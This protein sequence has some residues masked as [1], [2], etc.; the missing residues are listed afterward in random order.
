M[1]RSAYKFAYEY[2]RNEL[3]Y[4]RNTKNGNM[5][6]QKLLYFSQLVHYAEFGKPLFD[7]PIYAYENGCI[8]DNVLN[9]YRRYHY[10][11]IHDAYE[12]TNS[13][14]SEEQFTLDLVKEVYGDK[15]AEE[16]SD[17]NHEHECWK[18]AYSR[19]YVSENYKEKQLSKIEEDEAFEN[20]VKS[21]KK[22]VDAYKETREDSTEAVYILGGTEF[23]YDPREI[24]INDELISYLDNFAGEEEAFSIY[25]D[26]SQG[27]IVY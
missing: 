6:L 8:V 21:I 23:Y 17:L 9:D 18:L 19:S 20:D 5:K 16:L 14:T 2:I 12:A 11:F 27:V 10:Q 15:G 22:V 7:D 26:P 13:F 24:I 25:K 3:D 1:N 4:P